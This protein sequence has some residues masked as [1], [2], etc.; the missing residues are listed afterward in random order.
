MARALEFHYEG[1]SFRA[2]IE[3]VDR[4]ALY[5]EI[6]VETRDNSGTRCEVATL[7]Q[8]GR[9]LV[10]SGGTGLAYFKQD[11]SWLERSDLV[12]VDSRGGRVNMVPSSFDVPIELD[13]KTTPERLLDHSIRLAYL[14]AA[15]QPGV[16]APLQKALDQ[17]S[18]FKLDFSF[19]GGTSADPA[20]LLKGAEGDIWLLVGDDNNVSFVGFAQAAGLAEETS[21]A[22]AGNDDLDF[23]MM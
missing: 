20:F 21:A 22:D 17:G 15:E 4:S 12:T 7:A 19:R 9:T 8:D 23:D 18:I 6:E 2:G 16:P 5:G 11:G 3:K 1:Q 14:V 13:T 10:P